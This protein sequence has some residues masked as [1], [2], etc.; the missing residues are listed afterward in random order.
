MVQS[1]SGEPEQIFLWLGIAFQFNIKFLLSGCLSWLNSFTWPFV[2]STDS[3]IY[4]DILIDLSRKSK[5]A[6]W[7]C[8]SKQSNNFEPNKKPS[9]RWV[10]RT[11]TSS[12][13]WILLWMRIIFF[14]NYCIC[15]KIVL[16]F[17]QRFLP[18]LQ[19]LTCGFQI[20]NL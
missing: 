20:L 6:P 10:C 7:A 9:M 14:W 13:K 19:W 5:W 4:K 18:T 15:L 8:F 1:S 2:S 16:S 17:F 11:L 3:G 12:M